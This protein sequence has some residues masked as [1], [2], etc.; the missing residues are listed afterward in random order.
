MRGDLG[1]VI[2][3]RARALKSLGGSMVAGP[4]GFTVDH[5]G[6]PWVTD[7][8]DKQ[9]KLAPR[10]IRP[11]RSSRRSTRKSTPAFSRIKAA[12]LAVYIKLLAK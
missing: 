11:L 8:N 7:V 9:T 2:S 3:G 5:E 1:A 6:N 10:G 12:D 4:H